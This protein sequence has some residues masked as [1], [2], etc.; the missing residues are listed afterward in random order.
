MLRVGVGVGVRVRVRVYNPNPHP[1]PHP[2]PIPEQGDDVPPH[3]RRTVELKPR[4]A[5]IA[6]TR[7]NR[8][9]YIFLVARYRH[10]YRT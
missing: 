5:N 8:M 4:G 10:S 7:A 9:E 1:H 3:Q 2:N 6:V